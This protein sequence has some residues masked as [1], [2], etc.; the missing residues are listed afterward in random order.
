MR[1]IPTLALLLTGAL[2]AM[3]CEG[4][5]TG[6]GISDTPNN[7]TGTSRPG[8]LYIGVQA[9]QSVTFEGQL[10]RTAL[11]YS[12]QIAGT[13]RQ[14]IGFDRGGIDP[15][16][17]DAYFSSIYGSTNTVQGGGGLL[18]LH[19]MI[20]IAH[21]LDDSLYVGIGKV[22]EALIIGTAASIWGD[23]PYR[24][25]AD[26]LIETP[27]FD[28]QLQVYQ[29]VL[30]QL[31][32]AINVYLAAAPGGTNAGPPPDN[33]ELIYAGLS[34]AQLRAVYL[35]VAHSL[36]ARFH[37]HLAEVDPANYALALAEV[38]QGISSP[39]NDML[40]F[41]DQTPT[42]QSLWWQFM[43][44]RGDISPGSALIQI[45]KRRIAAGIEDQARLNFY[46]TSATGGTTPD[47]F[48]GFRP[49][50]A[51]GLTV[52]PGIDPGDGAGGA[53]SGFTFID[54]V[55]SP[56]DF[57]HPIITWAET[58]LIGAEA[59]FQA[60]GQAAAQPYLDAVRAN[61]IYGSSGGVPVTFPPL[62]SVP[63]TLQNIMEEKYVSLYLNMEVWND[64][65]ADLFALP[66]SRTARGVDRTRDFAGPRPTAIRADGDQRESQYA[67]GVIDRTESQ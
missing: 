18:D 15:G 53:Y 37:M 42:G 63:A 34:G 29:D 32:S 14:Q 25:A 61:R 46:F 16:N 65:Q 10:A 62:G 47:D 28:S 13:S 57:R 41:H 66:G 33:A 43:A 21:R 5:L 56:G 38:P 60:G 22:W 11:L 8:P 67:D 39:A 9:L 23:I 31:D 40:W 12:Q 6:P 64:L 19:K 54:G 55:A 2:S 51:T 26:S 7:P 27:A 30:T 24:E 4:F 45:L 17:T 52:A 36:K 35:Q 50:A 48:F 44:T 20:Q 59:A 58:Q 3:A 1:R 49:G